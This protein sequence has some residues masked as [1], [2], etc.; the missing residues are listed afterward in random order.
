MSKLL[1]WGAAGLALSAASPSVAAD[2]PDMPVKAATFAQRFSWTGCY[3]GA[4]AGGAFQRNNATDPVGVVQDTLNGGPITVGTTTTRVSPSGAVIGGQ[5][6]CDYQFSPNFVLGAEAAV[7]AGTLRGKTL[8]GLPASAPDS[9]LVTSK[10]DFMPSLTARL[11]YAADHWLF[12]AKGGVAW[13]GDKYSITGVSNTLPGGVGGPPTPFDFE[14][15]SLHVGWT[16]GAGV[17]WAFADDWSARLEYDYYDFGRQTVSM[18]DAANGTG[19]VNYKMSTQVIKLGV[20]FHV[21]GW[22]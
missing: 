14:G 13:S 1:F 4:H 18:T 20:N 15:V 16:A 9:A 21:W 22:Q 10:T 19:F 5:V 3:L 12:Y 2:F 11:G 7:S 6:G 17:E 8:V